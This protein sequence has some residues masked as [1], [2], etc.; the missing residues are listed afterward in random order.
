MITPHDFQIGVSL[1][2]PTANLI[3]LEFQQELYQ[4]DRITV[5]APRGLLEQLGPDGFAEHVT[6]YYLAQ[7]PSEVERVGRA[8]VLKAVK[9]AT[10]W[11][12]ADALHPEG[13]L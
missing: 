3:L 2:D 5:S 13:L 11:G 12:R 10:E 9:D 4:E 6:D 7:H 8:A 1:V